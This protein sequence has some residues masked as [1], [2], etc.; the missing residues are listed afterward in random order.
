MKKITNIN[1]RDKINIEFKCWKGC[2]SEMATIL[3][4]TGTVEERVCPGALV[5]GGGQRPHAPW[6]YWATSR[7]LEKSK[8]YISIPCTY[9]SQIRHKSG[10]SEEMCIAQPL[11]PATRDEICRGRLHRLRASSVLDWY[12]LASNGNKRDARRHL[13]VAAASG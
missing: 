7:A 12:W 2:I 9:E 3:W 5:S 8:V 13:I 6:A 4:V 10:D 11:K 1:S